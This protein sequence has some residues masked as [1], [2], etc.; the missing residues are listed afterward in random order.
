MSNINN[1][2]HINRGFELILNGGKKKQ[3]KTF[4]II[5]DKVV[6]FLKREL[7]IYFEFSLNIRKKK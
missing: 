1:S 5:L 4:H 7:T 6:F 2:A 3:P